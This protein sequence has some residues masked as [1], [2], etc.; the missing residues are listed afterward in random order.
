MIVKHCALPAEDTVLS[1]LC[2]IL[3]LLSGACA[4][5]PILQ[6]G[7]RTLR[8]G[9][10][11]CPDHTVHKWG[12]W[13]KTQV[14]KCGAQA[15]KSNATGPKYLFYLNFKICK[16]VENLADRKACIGKDLTKVCRD[17]NVRVKAKA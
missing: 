10:G 2:T 12:N 13:M 15:F 4:I 1:G 3:L 9:E 11:S 7:K 17:Q 8:R 14:A 6:T 5:A 16:S